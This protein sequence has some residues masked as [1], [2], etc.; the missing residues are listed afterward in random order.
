MMMLNK[1][2]KYL[3]GR[4]KSSVLV[5]KMIKNPKLSNLY[6]TEIFLD[7]RIEKVNNNLLT[8]PPKLILENTNICNAACI[9]CP[10]EKMTR[11][12]GVMSFELFKKIVDE[13]STS[14]H[15]KRLQMNNIGEPLLDP[16]IVKK[17]KYAKEKG[18]D[19]VFFFTNGSLLDKQISEELIDSELNYMVIS[20]DGITKKT[21]E[22]VRVNLKFG[23]VINNIK[24]FL[25]LREKNG[26]DKPKIELHITLL[27]ENRRDEKEF[28]K[29]MKNMVDY[30]SVT[31]A[32]D[33]AGQQEA[34]NIE[35]VQKSHQMKLAPCSN[36]WSELT[37]LWDGHVALCC[38][39]YEGK[40]I[41]GDIS[42]ETLQN[43]WSSEKLQKIRE[44]QLKRQFDQIELCKR[45]NEH[46]WA[47][48]WLDYWD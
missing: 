27:N 9:M 48:W 5:R 43:V 2:K 33:W 47:N 45:C 23:D 11:K 32:H 7:R 19:Q 12:K 21:Y 16:L 28:I 20:L 42:K 35:Y 34:K 24:N 22:K 13:Y 3:Y 36:L 41:L 1:T 38:M 17:I 39:D 10:Y 4:L 15:T 46:S 29:K 8:L 6:L 37:I 44:Y 26:S 31:Y 25:V 30:V 14:T 18:I 40:V